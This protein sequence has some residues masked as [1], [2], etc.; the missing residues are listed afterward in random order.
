MKNAWNYDIPGIDEIT[1]NYDLKDMIG[2]IVHGILGVA[3]LSPNISQEIVDTL[4]NKHSWS[5]VLELERILHN[6]IHSQVNMNDKL[7]TE[8]YKR[9]QIIHS[10]IQKYFCGE[11]LADIGSGHGLISWFSREQFKDIVLFD[12]VDY[13]DPEVTLPFI[14]YA[15]DEYPPFDRSYD[16]T[17]LITVLHHA[18]DPLKL[19]EDVWQHTRKRLIIIESVF[20]VSPGT[21]ISP[22]H[23]FDQ[24]TQ[25]V[26]AVFCDWFYNRVLN[27]DVFVPYNFNSPQNWRHIFESLPAKIFSEEDLGVDLDIVP[28]HHFLFVLDKI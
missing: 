18:S 20:D 1:S 25:F 13:R 4:F 3:G 15:G 2:K 19:L 9:A 17:L 6:K 24:Y 10:E 8:M 28:E 26:Y 12:V 16:C 5:N 27:Q 14:S 11:S 21:V 7:Q 22:L 23:K